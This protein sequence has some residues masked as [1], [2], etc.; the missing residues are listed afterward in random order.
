MTSAPPV[1]RP[2]PRTPWR[3][4]AAAWP[5]RPLAAVWGLAA[6]WA[7]LFSY[8][9]VRR[10]DAFWTGRFDLGN[11]VQ[12][13]WS[14][15]Q[16]RP[17]ETTDIAGEQFVRLG[18]HVDPILVLFAPLTWTGALPQALLV[19]QAVIVASG[20]LPAYWL[21][22][23]WLGDERLAVA[24]AAVYLLYPPLQWATLTEFHPVTLAAPLL[25]FCIWAAEERRYALLTVFAVLAALTKEEVGLALAVLGIWMIV[26]GLGR[27]YGAALAVAALAWVAVA[28][29]VIIPRFNEGQGSAFVDRYSSLGDDGAGVA[30]TL[31]TRPWEAAEL[32]ASYDR[33]SYLVA[34]LAPLAFLSLL[35]PLLAAGALPEVVINVLADWFP[36]YSIEFQ[37]VAVIVP[38]LVAAAILG[39]ARLRRADRPAWLARALERDGAVAAG[40]VAVVLAAGVYLGPLPWWGGVPVVGSDQRTEQFRSGEHAAAASRA[41][42]LIP[43]DVPVSAGNLMGAHLSERERILTFPVVDEARWVILD[44]RR[45]Y[46]GD[47][48]L[49]A[50]HAAAVA[51][52]R[53]RPDMRVVFDEDG[54]M[55]FRRARPGPGGGG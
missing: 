48:L 21:G 39:L 55:V 18:A 20:A 45:P 1:P 13:V 3:P 44:R 28:V 23:R 53:E 51:R 12:A 19:A 36:Q 42:A 11:M 32:V 6:V 5:R 52:L 24:A 14:T 49:P 26:R 17:L 46:L 25:L 7:G 22:R 43:D 4:R 31:L 54:V 38:F 47:R 2:L 8:L 10:H 35:A 16:G 29:L 15:A 37:Y 9:S 41:V 30:R 40:W 34:L 33:L 50:A 27:R